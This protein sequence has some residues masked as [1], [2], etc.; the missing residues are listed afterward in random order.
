MTTTSDTLAAELRAKVGTTSSNALRRE[1]KVPGVL[2][3]HGDEPTAIALNARTL[4]E[5]LHAGGRNRL[6]TIVLD[7]KRDTALV[8][9]VQRDP[10]SRRILH[11]DFQ[12]VGATE[13]ISATLPIATVGVAKGVAE[14][15]GVLELISHTIDVR[16]PA[17]ALPDRIEI[18]VTELGVH[19]HVS[20]GDLKLPP[21]ITLDADPATVLVSVAPSTVARQLEEEA[22]AGEAPAAAE[23]PLVSA[24]EGAEGAS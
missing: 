18:D 1:G 12:R 10:I 24:T 15:N 6:L 9:D 23:V 2:F 14:F 8:R 16:G 13:E 19:E 21:G 11:V 20:A 4:A 22:A 17:N 5:Q 3:G 7:G